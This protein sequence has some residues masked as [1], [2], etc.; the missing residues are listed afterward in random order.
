MSILSADYF[1]LPSYDETAVVSVL[2]QGVLSRSFIG[3]IASLE[4]S[5]VLRRFRKTAKSA[6]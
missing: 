3:K 4:I 2:I 5:D 1:G 6:C